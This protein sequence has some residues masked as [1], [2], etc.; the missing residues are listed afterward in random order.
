MISCNDYAF[1]NSVNVL[2]QRFS[3]IYATRDVVIFWFSS[4]ST[5][6]G[7]HRFFPFQSRRRAYCAPPA[8]FNRLMP[9]HRT[10]ASGRCIAGT[11]SILAGPL[12]GDVGN[13]QLKTGVGH[14]AATAHTFFIGS[15]WA[16]SAAECAVRPT[17]ESAG[18]A[19]ASDDHN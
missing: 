12:A 19:N 14:R 16:A 10:P 7:I 13:D 9:S 5:W 3:K 2:Q 18:K 8:F 6:T 4:L 11:S 15:T 1:S 17:P